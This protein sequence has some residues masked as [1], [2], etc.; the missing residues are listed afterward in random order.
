MGHAY[1]LEVGDINLDGT[2]DLIAAVITTVG[3]ESVEVWMGN[4][5]GTF[6]HIT[7]N[8]AVTLLPG[9]GNYQR[10]SADLIDFDLDGDLDLYLTGADGQN[11]G[12]GF[13]AVPNQFFENT[14]RCAA[15]L[16]G[17]GNIGASDLLALLASWGPCEDCPADLDGNGNVG[18]S[19]LL[20]LLASWGPCP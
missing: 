7:A 3:T 15:D 2:V 13:G 1:D 11:V 18:A 8:G 4:G 19:D 16:D 5:D 20:A 9:L 14:L 10:L 17:N 12:F 6:D